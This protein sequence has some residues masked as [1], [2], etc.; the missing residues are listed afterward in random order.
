MEIGE[1][2]NLSAKNHRN[3]ELQKRTDMDTPE[4]RTLIY[5]AFGLFYILCLLGAG[6]GGREPKG[7]SQQ[8]SSDQ[9]ESQEV[10]TTFCS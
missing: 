4:V 10:S 7:G 5:Y 2:V 3:F 8:T 6:Y 1:S 9:R